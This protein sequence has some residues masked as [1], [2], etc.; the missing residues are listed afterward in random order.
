MAV[1]TVCDIC[2]RE[3]TPGTGGI[4]FTFR[5]DDWAADDGISSKNRGKKFVGKICKQCV[6]NIKNYCRDYRED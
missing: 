4:D 3:I 1:V 5:V 2:R 6:K